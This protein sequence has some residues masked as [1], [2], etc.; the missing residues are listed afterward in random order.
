MEYQ[1]KGKIILTTSLRLKP[2][3][4]SHVLSA[5]EVALLSE[6]GKFALRGKVYAAII[7]LLDGKNNND[8][9]VGLLSRA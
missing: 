4:R 6:G 3:I 7:P 1:L 9:I 5:D 2:Y 8:T